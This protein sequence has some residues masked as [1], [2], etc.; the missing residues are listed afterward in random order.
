MQREVTALEDK[1]Q[2]ML[3]EKV[4]RDKDS[5]VEK[6]PDFAPLKSTKPEDILFNKIK[7][8]NLLDNFLSVASNIANQ[9]DWINSNNEDKNMEYYIK[10]GLVQIVEIDNEY[11]KYALS[12]NGFAVLGKIRLDIE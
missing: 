9:P 12:K 3:V 7:S 1:I 10:L 4:E 8:K 2:E 11:R 6:L 5:S